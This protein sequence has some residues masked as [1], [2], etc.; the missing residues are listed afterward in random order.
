MENSKDFHIE[1]EREM[2]IDIIG[3]MIKKKTKAR[4]NQ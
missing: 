1:R 4:N 2:L 3:F